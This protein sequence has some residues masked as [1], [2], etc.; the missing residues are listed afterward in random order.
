MRSLMLVVA[1]ALL[2]GSGLAD[3]AS[4]GRNI[5]IVTP[6]GSTVMTLHGS[7][8]AEESG[9]VIGVWEKSGN[10]VI[11]TYTPGPT[12]TLHGAG[13]DAASGGISA[14]GEPAGSWANLDWTGGRL[15]TLEGTSSAS[16]QP[17]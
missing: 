15:G 6:G 17:R 11:V 16:A 1:V 14:G 12:I 2:A 4:G 5:L 8:L 9:V 10:D 3:T 7:G 13:G